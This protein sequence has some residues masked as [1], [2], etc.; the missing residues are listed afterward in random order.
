MN[1]HEKDSIESIPSSENRRADDVFWYQSVSPSSEVCLGY[2]V[3]TYGG[4]V[5]QVSDLP[6]KIEEFR[7][8]LNLSMEYLTNQGFNRGYW[9]KLSTALIDHIQICVKEFSFYIHHAKREY[10]MLAKWAHESLPDPIPPHSTHQVGVGC[11]I[12]RPDKTILLVKERSGPASIG[13]G[14]WKL[15][16]GLV[17]S[18]ED[19]QTAAIRE[20]REETGID[21]EFNSI[22]AFRQSH[23]GS[24]TLGAT[25]DLFFVCLLYPIDD[26]QKI[27]LQESEILDARWVSHADLHSVSKCSEG[28]SARSL[29]ECVR[30]IVSGESRPK[31]CGEKLPAW[32]RKDCSQWIY[33]P[34]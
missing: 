20:A 27:V 13:G 9:M 31:I 23:G 11:V 21:C 24:P 2:R 8:K 22:L 16:T 26:S 32:R 30:K 7:K 28:T 4:V 1:F 6:E 14:I 10:V 3:D 18:V 17:E 5:F 12:Q 15:P 19:L 29:M 33:Q 25:S 34:F